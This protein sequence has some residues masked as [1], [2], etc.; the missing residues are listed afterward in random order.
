MDLEKRNK[1]N[2]KQKNK[3]VRDMG[4][5]KFMS[6]AFWYCLAKSWMKVEIAYM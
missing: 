3:A 5:I 1:N 4:T 2:K 6:F